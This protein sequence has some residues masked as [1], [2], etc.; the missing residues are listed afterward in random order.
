MALMA[1]AIAATPAGAASTMQTITANVASG[2]F[3]IQVTASRASDAAPN[4]AT[5]QFSARFALGSTQIFTL[6]GPVTC[7]D[8]RGNAVGLFYPITSSSPALFAQLHSGVFIYFRVG[9]GL[10]PTLVGF[11]PVPIATTKTCSP[12]DAL[13]PVTSGSV[14]ISS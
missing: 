13:L 1:T 5:G 3:H 7:L 8:I 9:S 6:Y 12:G 11:L 2:P 4:T 10:V 14:S